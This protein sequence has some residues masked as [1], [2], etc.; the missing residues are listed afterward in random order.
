LEIKH[1]KGT[2]HS[3]FHNSYNGGKLSSICACLYLII[4]PLK[5][6]MKIGKSSI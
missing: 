4:G 5:S 3:N 6:L 2:V 1:G